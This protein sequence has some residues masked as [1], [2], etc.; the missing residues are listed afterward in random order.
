MPYGYG[1]EFI[2]LNENHNIIFY[3][4]FPQQSQS[5]DKYLTSVVNMANEL[6]IVI[7]EPSFIIGKLKWFKRN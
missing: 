2:S 6:T 5:L 7:G 1:P 3:F 4:D